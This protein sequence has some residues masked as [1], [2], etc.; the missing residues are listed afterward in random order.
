MNGE[1]LAVK[2][3]V[4]LSSCMEPSVPL[5]VQTSGMLAKKESL[6][7]PRSR[8]CTRATARS[9]RPVHP[10]NDSNDQPQVGGACFTP[11]SPGHR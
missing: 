5:S 4:H 7:L 9:E 10:P 11:R 8:V 6:L 3:A 1:P 2:W